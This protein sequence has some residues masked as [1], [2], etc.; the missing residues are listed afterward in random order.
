MVKLHYPILITAA[1]FETTAQIIFKTNGKRYTIDGIT[2]C[3]TDDVREINVLTAKVSGIGLY[4]FEAI[5]D[6][7]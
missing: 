1:W 5:L 2:A 6:R 3:K 7:I 4:Q